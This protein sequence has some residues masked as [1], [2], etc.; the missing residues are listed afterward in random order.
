MLAPT[1]TWWERCTPA[2]STPSERR[3]PAWLPGWRHSTRRSPSH[4]ARRST[5]GGPHAAPCTAPRGS[6]VT[7]LRAARER[8]RL[9]E[10][11]EAGRH[12]GDG[13]S[14][15]VEKPRV[16]RSR[17][18]PVRV[19]GGER[20]LHLAIGDA[21]KRDSQLARVGDLRERGAHRALVHRLSP[22]GRRR[23]S[24]CRARSFDR[25]CRRRRALAAPR[26]CGRR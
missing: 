16:H 15:G 14:E 11:F 10:G 5:T 1:E 7:D 23:G 4:A 6:Q 21:I 26:V 13:L 2:C 18:S 8:E 22:R 20:H 3:W 24:Y 17:Q 9:L 12:A 19:G 25:P